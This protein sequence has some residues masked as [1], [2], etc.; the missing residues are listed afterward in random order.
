MNPS[1]AKTL[2]PQELAKLEHAFASDPSSDAYRPLA[3][4]YL[5][6]GRFMEAMVV[7][8]KGVKAHP[9]RPDARVLLARVYADQGKDKKAIEEL[10]AALGVA[11]DDRTI[12]RQLGALQMKTGEAATGRANLVKAWEANPQDPE[13]LA[14]MALWKVE[15]PRPAPPPE[16]VAPP[17]P[18]PPPARTQTASGRSGEV[19]LT[20]TP[21]NGAPAATYSRTSM[22]AAQ[23]DEERLA[24]LARSSSGAARAFFVAVAL[25]IAVVA[26]FYV[27]GQWTARRANIFSRSLK[28]ASEQ[29]K[30]DNF[31]SYKLASIAAEQALEVEPKAVAPHAY[32]A[33]AYAIRWGEHGD[34]DD[35]R[36]FAEEHLQAAKAG[37]EVDSHLYAADA[38]LQE[39]SGQGTRALG[40]L[41]RQ[42]KTFDEEGHASSLLYLT[43]GL[44]QMDAGDLE[45]ARESLEKAQALAPSDPRIY[46][47]LGAL[48]RRRGD[49]RA[50]EQNFGLALRYEKDHPASL[51]GL[52][53][54]LIEQDS[55]SRFPAAASNLKKLLEGEPPPSPRQLAV[56]HMARALL[57]A[58]VQA[59]LVSL[60]PD[61]Q[62]SLADR[63]GVPLDKAEATALGNKEEG[64][65]FNLDRNNPELLLLKGKRL[66]AEGQL[67]A[68]IH[69]MR[70][71][72]KVDPTRAQFY[73]DLA[74]ALMLKPEGA[75]EAQDALT[76]AIRTLPDSPRLMVLLGQAYRRQGHL[77]EAIAQFNKALADPKARNPDARLQ[78]GLA[79]REKG[80]AKEAEKQLVRASQ[81]YL[82][83]ARRIAETFT[84]LGRTYEA[85]EDRAR[86]DD[87]YQKALN[88]DADYPE[89]YFF[90]ARFLATDR[91]AKDK[92][93][94]SALAYLRLDPRGEH[95]AEAQRIAQ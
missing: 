41:T 77:D 71:A 75:R 6:M 22:R 55:P 38:L 16:P 34:G 56:A 83:Q 5:G 10:Q 15:A 86:A 49:T 19:P 70:E 90:Y 40:E 26:G 48:H 87:A 93:R 73:V 46:S 78:L 62:R 25:A 79:Y 35:A 67:D 63:T 27:W 21:V 2:S 54:L 39:Y 8:K 74:R 28:E 80:D 29:L 13:T 32:L 7:C 69:E 44:V 20:R 59:A 14:L 68:G 30:H 1:P 24:K 94:A 43:L 11:A 76:T 91:K 85:L 23:E 4:A 66:V 82:G 53:L 18:P 17:P 9:N 65:A 61:E 12:L 81:E 36:R 37:G 45:R 89:S 51:L 88:S 31:A 3:E 42:V 52:S 50:A 95:A 92:A 60:K 33:Y 57:I 64:E 84:E 58:R 47:A 72:V